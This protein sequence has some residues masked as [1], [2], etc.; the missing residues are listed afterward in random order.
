MAKKLR[1]TVALEGLITDADTV[2]MLLNCKNFQLGDI[3]DIF[4]RDRSEARTLLSTLR[5]CG[6]IKKLTHY[7]KKTPPFT[8]WLKDK[9]HEFTSEHTAPANFD[10][11][12]TPFGD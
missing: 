10:F 8:N 1:H 6:A 5:K 3:E 11:E 4:A 12:E 9:R 7:Y 2:N